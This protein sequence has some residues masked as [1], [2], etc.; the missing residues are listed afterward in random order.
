MSCVEYWAPLTPPSPYRPRGVEH[1]ASKGNWLVEQ[2]ESS[3]GGVR[4]AQAVVLHLMSSFYNWP[5][6]IWHI[7]RPEGAVGTYSPRLVSWPVAI[8]YPMAAVQSLVGGELAR[9]SSRHR[10][11]QIGGLGCAC[12]AR[13]TIH[14]VGSRG[15]PSEYNPIAN[16]TGFLMRTIARGFVCALCFVARLGLECSGYFGKSMQSGAAF[17]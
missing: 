9:R 2:S 5:V 13:R 10:P 11:T 7:C 12:R 16:R 14:E 17:F 15:V 3:Q 6:R 4:V 8:E 1:T